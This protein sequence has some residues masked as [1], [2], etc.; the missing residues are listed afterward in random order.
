MLNLAPVF[1]H[2]PQARAEEAEKSG[3]GNVT[4]GKPRV[5]FIS[6]KTDRK[7]NGAG[8]ERKRYHQAEASN[9]KWAD[10]NEGWDHKLL[11]Q[12][13]D[14]VSNS[15]GIPFTRAPQASLWSSIRRISDYHHPVLPVQDKT[16][17]E[18]LHLILTLTLGFIV[19]NDRIGDAEFL[20]RFPHVLFSVVDGYTDN[21][22]TAVLEFCVKGLKGRHLLNTWSAPGRPKVEK[23]EFAVDIVESQRR[24][25]WRGTLNVG[26]A[27][28]RVDST[29]PVGAPNAPSE[30][31]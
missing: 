12:R 6:L 25:S 19:D 1:T 22:K 31:R 11:E 20:N 14:K 18:S 10:L 21:L 3:G 8:E 28:S 23:K 15:R 29:A 24:T 5:Y 27:I 26:S 17:G 9:R 30:R 7:S 13:I 4:F 16:L 2:V